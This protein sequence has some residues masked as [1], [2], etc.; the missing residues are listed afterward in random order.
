MSSNL[1]GNWTVERVDRLR[2]LLADGL[3]T[4]QIA[5]ELGGITRNAVIGKAARMGIGFC[6]IFGKPKQGPKPR[7]RVRTVWRPKPPKLKPVAATDLPPE[8]VANP[9]TLLELT[10]FT[11]RWPVAGEPADMLFC[12]ALPA[13]GKVYCPKHCD[14]AYHMPLVLS[15]HERERRRRHFMKIARPVDAAHVPPPISDEYR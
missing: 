8:P 9:V 2:A 13:E 15:A 12:G 14:H 6:V 11:C 4:S 7:D 10:E 5:N 3:S 1:V